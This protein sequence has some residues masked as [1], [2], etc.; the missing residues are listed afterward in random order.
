MT[1]AFDSSV[2]QIMN[3][4]SNGSY[5]ANYTAFMNQVHSSKKP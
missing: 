3:S 2:R 1:N 5:E 4:V